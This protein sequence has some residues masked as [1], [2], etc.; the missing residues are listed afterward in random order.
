MKKNIITVVL[1]ALIATGCKKEADIV[2]HIE[3]KDYVTGQPVSQAKV[4]GYHSSGYDISCLCY[5]N[6][7]TNDKGYTNEQ[8]KL[9]GVLSFYGLQVQKDGYYDASEYNNCYYSEYSH[10]ATFQLFKKGLFDIAL[11]PRQYYNDPPPY[12]VIYPV[13]K[14]GA[15]PSPWYGEAAHYLTLRNILAAGFGDMLNRI[16]ILKPA[17]GP[18]PDTLY[19]GD[20]FLPANTIKPVSI[21]Y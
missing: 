10:T 20:V 5:R 4:V 19:K 7:S 17:A 16:M 6:N 14:N 8:G 2:L 18:L 21:A 1:A 3:V 9:D 11:S 12:L 13:L 15:I